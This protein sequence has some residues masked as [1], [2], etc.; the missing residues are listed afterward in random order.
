MAIENIKTYLAPLTNNERAVLLHA[1]GAR[2]RV[3]RT[4]SVEQDISMHHY[5][6][7]T[8]PAAQ[9]E[10]A[11]VSLVEKGY[12]TWEPLHGNYCYQRPHYRY[13]SSTLDGHGVLIGRK[14]APY[15]KMFA[16]KQAGKW[17]RVD[18]TDIARIVPV[19][20]VKTAVREYREAERAAEEQ[21]KIAEAESAESKTEYL[22]TSLEHAAQEFIAARANGEDLMSKGP[23][24]WYRLHETITEME[25]IIGTLDRWKWNRDSV[26]REAEGLRR[27][28]AA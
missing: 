28:V 18:W 21:S 8:V 20:D 16:E 2:Y 26:E 24:G 1:A 11:A 17:A 3:A 6:D 27:K 14:A 19:E 5:R 9:I 10:K 23:H 4:Q 12:A 13:W 15:H 22:L 7:T 25:S